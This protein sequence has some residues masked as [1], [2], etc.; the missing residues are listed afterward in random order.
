MTNKKDLIDEDEEW[1]LMSDEEIE[2]WNK[3]IEEFVNKVEKERKIDELFKW[4][5]G[6]ISGLEEDNDTE[7]GN[8]FD[9]LMDEDKEDLE[10]MKDLDD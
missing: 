4:F 9:K 8:F 3:E 10:K 7:N 5:D 2:E 6:I 1:Y